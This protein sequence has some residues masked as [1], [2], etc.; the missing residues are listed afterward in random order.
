MSQCKVADVAISGSP[1][2][3]GSCS[4]YV[5]RCLPTGVVTRW[6]LRCTSYRLYSS[7]RSMHVTNAFNDRYTNERMTCGMLANSTEGS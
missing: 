6:G 1:Y 4:Q 3:Y 5:A 7:A 2:V